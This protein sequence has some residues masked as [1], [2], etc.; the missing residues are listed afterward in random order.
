MYILHKFLKYVL[1]GQYGC[2]L[3]MA[4]ISKTP[5]SFII[6][7]L[8]L[9]HP[10]VVLYTVL[11]SA[12]FSLTLC[13]EFVI[14]THEIHKNFML[15]I[16]DF[17]WMKPLILSWPYLSGSGT[18]CGSSWSWR[19]CLNDSCYQRSWWVLFSATCLKFWYVMLVA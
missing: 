1:H 19:A 18:K 16:N 10:H 15:F 17:S 2:A 11:S 14:L 3:S 9:Q 6:F 7:H 4:W 13:E 5:F 8:T 12:V